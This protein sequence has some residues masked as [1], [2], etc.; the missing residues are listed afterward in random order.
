MTMAPGGGARESGH[1][2]RDTV[3][4]WRIFKSSIQS[5]SHSI[6]KIP[7]SAS[8]RTSVQLQERLESRQPDPRTATGPPSLS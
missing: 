1:P 2:P 7:G 6:S 8:S 5:I 4:A 3:T